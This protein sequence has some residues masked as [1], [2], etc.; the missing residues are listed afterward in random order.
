MGP[1]SHIQTGYGIIDVEYVKLDNMG[2]ILLWLGTEAL[3]HIGMEYLVDKSRP[4]RIF[5]RENTMYEAN[6]RMIASVREA[7]RQGFQMAQ[8]S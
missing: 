1:T 3:I 2:Q 5:C 4:L 6:Q 7:V 8:S